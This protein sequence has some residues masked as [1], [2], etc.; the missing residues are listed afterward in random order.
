MCSRAYVNLC[1]LVP[2][3]REIMCVYTQQYVCTREYNV[4]CRHMRDYLTF[5]TTGTEMHSCHR[6]RGRAL[7][8]TAI[9]LASEVRG[10]TNSRTRTPSIMHK[11]NEVE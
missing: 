10:V 8:S 9:T 7:R 1:L 6:R 4:V 11:P 3:V 5:R 2:I